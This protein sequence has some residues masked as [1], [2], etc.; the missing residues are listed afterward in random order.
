MGSSSL[1]VCLSGLTQV[2][3]LPASAGNGRKRKKFLAL[4]AVVTVRRPPSVLVSQFHPSALQKK[5][6]LLTVM[7][8]PRFFMSSFHL[9]GFLSV[10]LVSRRRVSFHCQSGTYLLLSS[11]LRPSSRH[12]LKNF[13]ARAKR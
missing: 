1:S 13:F 3:A 8:Y 9:H 5:N 6:S 4:G 12:D 2:A 11:S 10:W 7:G